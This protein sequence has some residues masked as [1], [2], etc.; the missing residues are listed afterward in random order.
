MSSQ[1]IVNGIPSIKVQ[2]EME[3][4][5]TLYGT[6]KEAE[7]VEA[8]QGFIQIIQFAPGRAEASYVDC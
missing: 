7:K 6:R 1:Y 4:G 5:E 3:A 2:V 8:V